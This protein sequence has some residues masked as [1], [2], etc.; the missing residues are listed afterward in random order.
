[1]WDDE[2]ATWPN[3]QASRF[4][5]AAGLRWHVQQM[6]EGPTLLLVHGTGASTHSWRDIMPSLAHHYSVIAADLPGHGFTDPANG[7][8]SSIA[9]MSESM[10]A[11]LN[12]M[13]VNPSYCVGHS[14]GA[15]VLCKMALDKRI[16]P[17]VIIGLNGAFLPLRGAAGL[18]FSPMARVLTHAA[19]L[20]R[21]IA[22]RTNTADVARLVAGTGSALDAK[23]IELYARLVRNPRHLAGAI[24]M[25]GNWDLYAFERELP[26]LP[27]PLELI[28]AE[29]DLTIPPRQAL[30]V[31]Q[32]VRHTVIH[33]L[34][35]LGHLAHEESPA[36]VA[37]LLLKIC[38]RYA[39]QQAATTPGGQ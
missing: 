4:V 24:T 21:L 2:K 27:V 12:A 13:G 33:R 34:A 22:R 17:R 39:D 10:A 3:S 9:G 32:R 23:G 19:F 15:V 25:M 35:G 11:L 31:Q 36:Q 5:A 6:G 14:A 37:D 29:R 16:A 1:L 8:A 30:E 20:P 26:R 18:L 28:V 7:P 38:R